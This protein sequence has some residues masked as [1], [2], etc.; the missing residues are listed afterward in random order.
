MTENWQKQVFFES[1]ARALLDGEGPLL[2]FLD[3]IQWCDQDTLEWLW[4]FLRYDDQ[5]RVLLLAAIRAEE[6]PSNAGLRTLLADLRAKGKLTEMELER[7]DR[8]QT[9][10]LGKHLLRKDLSDEAARSLFLESEGVPLFVVELANASMRVGP[11]FSAETNRGEKETK[12]SALGLPPRLR[13]VLDGRLARLSSP[14]RSAAE[15]AA[16]IGREFDFNLLR[17]ISEQD[18]STLVNALD[19]LWRTRMIRERGGSYD[20]SHDKLREAVLAGISPMRLRW[21]HQLAGE[22]LEAIEGNTEYAR[23][24]G[25]FE[26]AGLH[27]KASVYYAKAA[28]Q[29]RQL[30][31][32]TEAREHL[33]NALLLETRHAVLANLHEQRGDVLMILDRREDALRAFSQAY[34]LSEDA[35]Q[36]ARVSRKQV[37][38][39]GRY[40]P[41]TAREKY[42]TA[43]QELSHAQDED[44]YWSEWIETKLTW[45]QVRY[46]ILDIKEMNE[47]MEQLRIPIELHGSLHQKI[48]YRYILISLAF[49]KERF[50]LDGSHMMLSQETIELA[51]ATNDPYQI[52]NAKRQFGMVALFAG[53]I[54]TA[55]AEL[56]E[57]ISLCDSNG[58]RNAALIARVYLSLTHRRQCRPQD[59]RDDTDL[60]Q[61]QLQMVSDNPA[62]RGIVA[63]NNSW[64]SFLDGDLELARMYARSALEIWR[65]HHDHY[66]MQWS[67][68]FV[69]FAIAVHEEKTDEALSCARALLTPTQQKLP[70]EL[71]SALL[72]AL[73]ADA[74]NP[75][76]LL[77]LCKE[78]VNKAR[79]TGYL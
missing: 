71:E 23:I 78:V 52:S 62:Y 8:E 76:I 40:E 28:G 6:L 44:G 38:L 48:E 65:E 50:F 18:E 46:W 34:G 19:E 3:D 60:L 73:Q 39:T 57:V 30:F 27:T 16:V 36:K 59:V 37:T 54:E 63:A 13:A 69:L 55:E 15:M 1:M 53:Q 64:L 47:L 43:V 14:A 5:A 32:F 45:F 7:L 12:T 41:E 21:L 49:V 61:G 20:F 17:K 25:H 79:E 70:S 35:L 22:A 33:K 77:A 68:L 2:L 4:Y 74:T 11:A 24:A 51:M 58:D 29:A 10:L 9:A 72:S 26:R 56:Q 31:A 67:A 42:L 66:P 75:G